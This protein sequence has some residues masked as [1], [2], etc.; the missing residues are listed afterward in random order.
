MVILVETQ[1]QP[2]ASREPQESGEERQMIFHGHVHL[3]VKPTEQSRLQK[4]SLVMSRA[5][6]SEAGRSTASFCQPDPALSE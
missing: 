5:V 1:V 6:S 3:P 4:P 2:R